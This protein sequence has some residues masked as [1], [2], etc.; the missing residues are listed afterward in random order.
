MSLT[1]YKDK[2]FRSYNTA[3]AAAYASGRDSYNPQ[4]YETILSH[5]VRTGGVL[6]TVLD[7]GCGS[8][9]ATRSIAP[10]FGRAIGIDPSAEMI[11]AARSLGGSA[12][13]GAIRYENMPAEGCASTPGVDAESVDLVTA[14]MAV[15]FRVFYLQFNGDVIKAHWFDMN[16]FWREAANILRPSGTVALWTVASLYCRKSSQRMA[17]VSC[18]RHCGQ[19]HQCQRRRWFRTFFSIWSEESLLLTPRSR[20]GY[21]LACTITS[22]CPGPSRT[23]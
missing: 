19:I 4:L 1:T 3:Q 7:V 15:R 18:H 14:A 16:V 23:P 6:G 20:T 17:E 5:H 13:E 22:S 2:T 12:K 21:P 10:N 8:G 9:N 11:Q